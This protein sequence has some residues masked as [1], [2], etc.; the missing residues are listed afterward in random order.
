MIWREKK[1]KIVILDAKPLNPGDV[2]WKPLEAFGD[3]EIHDATAPGEIADRVKDAQ[4]VLVNKV[5]IGQEELAA[6]SSCRLVGA[7]ATGVNNLDIDALAGAGIAV[8][9]VPG[10][11]VFD[12][13]QH[14]IALLLEVCNNVGEEADAVRDGEWQRR[15]VWCYWRKAPLC[16]A[17]LVLGIIGFGAIG[18]RVGEIG[19]ALGMGVLA[20]GRS[21]NNPPEW[22]P[23]EY[24][25]PEEIFARSNVICLHC[26]L[27]PETAQIV[28]AQNIARM[29]HGG[30]IINT[31]RGGLVDEWAVA[32]A[33]KSGQLYGYG[34][35]VLST[36]PPMA[37]NPLL[38]A[39]NAYITPHL[40]WATTAARQRIIDIMAENL[41][42][43]LAGSKKNRIA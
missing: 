22:G 5:K 36:E 35:D 34:A 40:A 30:I 33:L 16:L 25:S 38:H 15:G 19:H 2:S 8:C 26:P 13:A 4:I 7:L 28:N 6:L 42:A 31:A 1:M 41:S 24:V 32:Q 11:G 39:P 9:N 17:G 20:S 21:R 3:L 43:F 23:F 12:V 29:R 10:Y 14:T 37:D 27:T 18:R